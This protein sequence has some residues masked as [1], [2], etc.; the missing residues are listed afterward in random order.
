MK[1][2]LLISLSS[3]N[4]FLNQAMKM[5]DATEVVPINFVFFT[6]SA[7][8]AGMFQGVWVSWNLTKVNLLL[9]LKSIYEATQQ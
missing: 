7:I 4:R 9:C 3:L 2:L 1:I 5:F 8:I 6:A